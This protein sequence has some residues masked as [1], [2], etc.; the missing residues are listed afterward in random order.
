MKYALIVLALIVPLTAS[1]TVTPSPNPK[2]WWPT[3][4]TVILLGGAI[5]NDTAKVFEERL[6]AMAGGPDAQI[7][8]IPTAWDFL[9]AQ[10]PTSG[11]QPSEIESLRR[12]LESRG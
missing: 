11:P 2:E 4:G 12:Q 8:V 3:S 6:I 9:P 5:A 7:V 1:Q 10:L